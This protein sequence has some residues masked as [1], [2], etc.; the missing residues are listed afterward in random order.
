MFEF[1]SVRGTCVLPG[2]KDPFLSKVT[3]PTG[4]LFVSMLRRSLRGD[5]DD[6]GG[7]IKKVQDIYA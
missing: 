7:W 3:V 4:F 1:G 6:R 2:E 5:T